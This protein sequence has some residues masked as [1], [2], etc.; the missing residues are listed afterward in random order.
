MA[1]QVYEAARTVM[2]V[3]EYQDKEVPEEALRRIVE[4]GRL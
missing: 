1:N 4:A 2:A 3:R